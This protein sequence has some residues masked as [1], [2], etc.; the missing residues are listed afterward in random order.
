[1]SIT[2]YIY[3]RDILAVKGETLVSWWNL[4]MITLKKEEIQR[5]LAALLRGDQGRFDPFV[6]AC[7]YVSIILMRGIN[8][9]KIVWIGL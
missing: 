3:E 8:V 9:M 1:M 5:N 7:Q 2:I 4:P 6:H